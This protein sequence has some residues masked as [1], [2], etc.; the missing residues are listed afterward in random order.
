MKYYLD[1]KEI[2][3]EELEEVRESLVYDEY[4]KEVILLWKIE[5]DAL[6]FMV[7]LYLR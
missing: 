6:Y 2:T 7:T 3:L 4:I 1:D 5:P